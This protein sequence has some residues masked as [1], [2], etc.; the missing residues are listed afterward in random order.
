MT[1]CGIPLAGE[2]KALDQ[3]KEYIIVNYSF[4][5]AIIRSLR[6]TI[7]KGCEKRQQQKI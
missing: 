6:E 5:F 2:E 7:Q 1:L 3:N 4:I